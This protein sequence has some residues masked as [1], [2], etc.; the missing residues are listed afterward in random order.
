MLWNW[1]RLLIVAFKKANYQKYPTDFVAE[2]MK[3]KKLEKSGLLTFSDFSDILNQSGRRTVNSDTYIIN[4]LKMEDPGL[5]IDSSD[6]DDADVTVV[7][8]NQEN[9]GNIRKDSGKY[10]K[11]SDESCSSSRMIRPRRGR[12]AKTALRGP[13]TT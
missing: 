6:D 7:T 2:S 8:I 1:A 12:G 10:R 3:K 11:N 13:I 5:V 4:D 9:S